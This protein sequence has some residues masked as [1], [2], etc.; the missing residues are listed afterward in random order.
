MMIAFIA[1][2]LIIVIT[3]LRERIGP[4]YTGVALSNIL[5]FSGTVKAVVTSWV[6]LEIALGAVMRVRDFERETKREESPEEKS[7]E[8]ND[9][10]SLGAIEFSGVTAS[11]R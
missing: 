2:V 7:V 1:L 11:Y 9:W 4:G 8:P 5:G 6:L 10:P 3:T